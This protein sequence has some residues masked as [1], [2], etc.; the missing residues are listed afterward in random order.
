MLKNLYLFFMKKLVRHI[1]NKR[2]HN[3]RY[4]GFYSRNSNVDLSKFKT[5][6]TENEIKK[7]NKILI[8]IKN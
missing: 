8:G 6:Y 2:F 5:L 7:W 4:C 1:P 3:I